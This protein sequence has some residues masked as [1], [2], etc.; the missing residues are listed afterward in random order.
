MTKISNLIQDLNKRIFLPGLQREFVWDRDQIELLFDSLIREYPVG[1]IT[2]WDVLHSSEEYHS[3]KFIQNFIDDTGKTPDSVLDE[4]FQKYNETAG[5]HGDP[6]LLVIDGQQRLTSIYIGLFGKIA[7]YTRGKGGRRSNPTHWSSYRLCVNLFGHP[8]FTR[9]NLEGDYQFKFRRTSDFSKSDRFGYEVGSDGVKRYWYPLSKFM[10]ERRGLKSKNV[11]RSE[12]NKEIDN[13]ELKEET[14]TDLKSIRTN[15]V[16]DLDSRILDEELPEKDVEQSSE[17]IKEIF[18]RMNIEGESPDPYQLLLSRMMSSWPFT[19]P[20]PS[21]FNP[22]EQVE[23]WIEKFQENYPEYEEKIDRE[24]FMRY[25]AFLYDEMLKTKTIQQLTEDE[26]LDMRDLWLRDPPKG[27]PYTKY[28]WFRESLENSLKS[29]IN[30]GF[31]QDTMGA[32]AMI[33]SIG[34]FYYRNPDASPNNSENLNSIYQ[35]VSRLLFLKQSKNSLGRV[36]ARRL[37]EFLHEHK[38]G[39]FSVFPQEKAFEPLD[40]DIARET[41]QEA[42]KTARY[43]E[44]KDESAL[45]VNANIAAIL[46][47]SR[48]D[49]SLGDAQDIEIDHIF[50]ASESDRVRKLSG[51]SKEEFTIHR[52]GNLQLLKSSENKAKSAMMP[53]DWLDSLG[54]MEEEKYRRLNNYPSS[55]DLKPENYEEFVENRERILL[56]KVCDAIIE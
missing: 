24:L 9:S 21:K 10:N 48:D 18:Q 11:I 33:A 30:I 42:I 3:Y 38:E 41:V 40:V 26:M 1:L 49:F 17:D 28:D 36:E 45:F 12:T 39:E 20:D 5:K 23:D 4:G 8:D 51:M 47:L 22:R 6:Q 54:K 32:Q 29:L 53:A 16:S 31:S 2:R 50:P 27:T 34:V 43:P 46:G 25:S 19:G 13:L 52:V 56:K 14:R 35:F 55:A 37:S 15:V 44:G 7:E